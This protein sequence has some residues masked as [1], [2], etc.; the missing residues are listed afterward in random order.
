MTATPPVRTTGTHATFDEDATRRYL[1]SRPDQPDRADWAAV[2]IED[3]CFLGEAVLNELD[4]HNQSMNFRIALAGPH[5]YDRGYGTEITRLVVD[6]PFQIEGRLREALH[7]EGEWVDS[8][9]MSM[10]ASDPRPPAPRRPEE[11]ARGA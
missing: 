6:L 3:G 5:V 7:W 1:D 11:S 10:L 8:I 4:P 2:R 9:L